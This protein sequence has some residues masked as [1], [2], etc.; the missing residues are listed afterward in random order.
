MKH[1]K[2]IDEFLAVA[3]TGSFSK[4][5]ERLGTAVSNVSKHVSTLEDNLGVKLFT[6]NT[7][8][9]QL[10]TQGQLLYEASHKVLAEFGQIKDTL[11]LDNKS[12]TG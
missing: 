10:T 3:E 4:A 1:W 5:A 2:G 12:L 9:I 8:N 7:R 6:R 11:Q